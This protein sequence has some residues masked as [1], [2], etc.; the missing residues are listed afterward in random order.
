MMTTIHL[1]DCLNGCVICAVRYHEGQ[2]VSTCPD[3]G[4]DLD[5]QR[6]RA[7]IIEWKESYLARGGK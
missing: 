5:E 2:E 1:G 3:C 4:L 7:R 6:E